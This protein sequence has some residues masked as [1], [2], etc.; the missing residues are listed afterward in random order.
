MALAPYMDFFKKKKTTKKKQSQAACTNLGPGHISVATQ[1]G[2]SK[3]GPPVSLSQARFPSSRALRVRWLK[4]P[5]KGLR[6]MTIATEGQRSAREPAPG[7]AQVIPATFKV[8][9]WKQG[10]P[11]NQQPRNTAP[12]TKDP[13]PPLAQEV[14]GATAPRPDTEC[15]P[16]HQMPFLGGKRSRRK[17]QAIWDSK[18][19]F[20][21]RLS[22]PW[23]LCLNAQ[24]R[25]SLKPN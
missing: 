15:L 17:M 18:H 2:G 12:I 14:L 11:N 21:E 1:Q 8:W 5:V 4:E 3:E 16:L 20:L 25:H 7:Q 23:R 22:V 24:I 9:H 19:F 10:S 13:A 6:V